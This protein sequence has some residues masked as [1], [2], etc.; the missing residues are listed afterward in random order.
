MPTQ[1][2][3]PL[4][5]GCQCGAVRYL[6]SEPPLAVY[7]CHCT[8]CQRQSGSAFGMSM[9][10]RRTAL[11]LTGGELTCWSRITDSGQRVDCYFC[12]AC[13]TRLFHVPAGNPKIANLKPG[14]LD[15]T[16]W[17]R[18]AGHM[19]TRSKQCWIE[20]PA[21][22]FASEQQPAD[23][24]PLFQVWQEKWKGDPAGESETSART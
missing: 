1:I 15:D 10:L 17:V 20:I 22:V 11:A 16:R 4:A 14:T 18:P 23:F 3:L 2:Q 24:R 21:D 8:E 6:I 5:G 7:V 13:G 19:W 9:P 12:A